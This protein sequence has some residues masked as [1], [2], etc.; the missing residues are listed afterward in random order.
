M[1]VFAC[2]HGYA[3]N[4]A[5]P[6]QASGPSCRR[7][8]LKAGGV[9]AKTPG[10][11]TL[12]PPK[13]TRGKCLHLG[14]RTEFRPGCGGRLCK[15]VCEAGEAYAMPGGV[16]Q[17][18]PKWEAD[19]PSSPP[20]LPDHSG[21][22]L[23]QWKPVPTPDVRPGRPRLVVTLV[24]GGEAERLNE[25]TGPSQR[26][27]AGRV[28]A[29]YAV[30]RGETQ[31]S[32]MR[33]AEKW[34]VRDYVPHYPGGT[35]YLDADVWV[36]PT[37]PDLF[38]VVPP[39]SIGLRD[40]TGQP[41]L[42]TWAEPEY[43]KLCESQGVQPHPV[44]LSRYWNSGVWLGRPEHADYWTPPANPYPATHCTEEHWC[45]HT[46]AERGWDVFD[47]G[48]RFNWLWY[49]DRGCERAAGCDFLHFAGMSQQVGEWIQ[50]NAA[51]RKTL[52]RLVAAT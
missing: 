36:R 42:L 21:L 11:G 20:P 5:E 22:S 17:T 14:V 4:P 8:W 18:C 10:G 51:W 32:R 1:S 3:V 7:C 23:P 25:S 6:F 35:L 46:L 15:H 29:D 12:T 37:A 48:E 47:L 39:H 45:R 49:Q 19:E 44:A 43:R 16:C 2:P 26:A 9:P 31:D 28:N 27:Y 30:I 33:C 13:P 50:D 41:K 40:I 38:E 52:L 34:R 24:V